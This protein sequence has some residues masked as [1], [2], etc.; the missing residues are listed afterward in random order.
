M[1]KLFSLIVITLLLASCGN[2]NSEKGVKSEAKNDVI[3]TETE[4]KP[5]YFASIVP[6]A[7]VANT[8][9][10]DNVFTSIIPAG[11]TPHGFD[12]KVREIV[13]IKESG[14][15]LVTDT[16]IDKAVHGLSDKEFI[17]TTGIEFLMTD[18][19]HWHEEHHEG[20]HHEEHSEES[21]LTVDPHFWL[22]VDEVIVLAENIKNK[23]GTPE[24]ETNFE[25][26]K[27]GV[28]SKIS[29]FKAISENKEP[30]K[31]I[32][33]HEAYNYL[34]ADL[35]I[36]GEDYL[37]IEDIPTV[38]ANSQKLKSLI[39]TI[40]KDNIKYIFKE[41]QINSKTL[42]Y[43]AENHNIEILVLDPLWN[44]PSKGGYIENLEKNLNN[45][46]KVYE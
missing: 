35:G 38:E 21:E 43:L 12:L 37:V 10:W 15:V 41:P 36:H 28:E 31:F 23:L 18:H 6:V 42:D 16:T 20:E 32:I 29:G 45:L 30:G 27:T 3:I 33:L 24:S 7:S 11:T 2:E 17:P 8:I 14:L 26:F 13:K 19:H 9:Y 5:E 40:E 22:W 4:I 39:D 34:F 46:K 44:N 25:E 1:K